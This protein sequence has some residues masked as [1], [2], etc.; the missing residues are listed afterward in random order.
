MNALQHRGPVDARRLHGQARSSYVLLSQKEQGLPNSVNLSGRGV[1][2]RSAAQ[3]SSTQRACSHQVL[4]EVDHARRKHR[5]PNRIN[6][7]TRKMSTDR[8]NLCSLL[9]H[10]AAMPIVSQGYNIT[11]S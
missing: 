2:A 1:C 3:D 5:Q 10:T 4:A 6:L 8:G 9:K 7:A 11:R